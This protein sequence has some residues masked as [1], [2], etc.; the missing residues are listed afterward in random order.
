MSNKKQ[1]NKN[2]HAGHRTR[3]KNKALLH[4][5]DSFEDHE[6]LEMLLYPVIPQKDTNELAHDLINNFGSFYA[7]F[8]APYEE[9]LKIKGMTNSAAFLLKMMTENMSRYMQDKIKDD[10][11]T[12]SSSEIAYRILSP[13]YIGKKDEV[14]GVILMNNIGRILG[15]EM[16]S[17]GIVNSVEISSRKIVELC[18]KYGATQIIISHNHPSGNAMPSLDDFNAT[19]TISTMLKSMGVRLLD[20]IIITDKGFL[21]M[22]K[23]SDFKMALE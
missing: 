4:G 17:S 2:P 8:D 20:H 16:L 23:M 1:E 9:L 21:S 5:F 7:V 18:V 13:K 15:C 10:F 11:T 22:E 19:K 3:M 14:V 6:F 12:I